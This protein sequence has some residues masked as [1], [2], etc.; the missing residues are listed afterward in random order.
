MRSKAIENARMRAIAMVKPLKQSVG[1]AIHI[2]DNENYNDSPLQD[3][4][5]GITAYGFK[6]KVSEDQ[7]PFIEFDKIKIG[8]NINVKFT[9]N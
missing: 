7:L 5:T 9:L 3:R 1:N 6:N 8:A 2:A 4:A